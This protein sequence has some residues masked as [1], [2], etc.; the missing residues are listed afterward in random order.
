MRATHALWQDGGGSH[1]DPSKSNG[2]P[3]IILLQL[4]LMQMEDM[5]A[6]TAFSD[7]GVRTNPSDQAIKKLLL[8]KSST[9][10]TRV[11]EERRS[12]L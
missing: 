12:F 2:E 8:V 10:A 11:P 4:I 3:S 7:A 1:W 6:P 5:A 9:A